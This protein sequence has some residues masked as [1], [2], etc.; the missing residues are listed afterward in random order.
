MRSRSRRDDVE[1]HLEDAD[2]VRPLVRLRVDALEAAHGRGGSLRRPRAPRGRS[3]P[4]FSDLV[5]R[6]LVERRRCAASSAAICSGSVSAFTL[7]V[8]D[9][10]E[11]A[12][13]RPRRCRCA[14]GLE[15]REVQR[16]DVERALVV[17]ERL[18]DLAHLALEQLAELGE[19]L[20]AIDVGDRDVERARERLRPAAASWP[21][22][23]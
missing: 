10:D 11:L 20:L 8:E 19:D 5:E 3:A 9:V 17:A 7:R 21:F 12:G 23:R 16:I 15:R 2:E 22:L 1:L 14:R 13:S 18:I 6:C 4:A